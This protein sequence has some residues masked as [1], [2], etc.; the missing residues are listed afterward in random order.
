MKNEKKKFNRNFRIL[1]ETVVCGRNLR[2][3]ETKL[4]QNFTN[5]RTLETCLTQLKYLCKKY[6]YYIISLFMTPKNIKYHACK[7]NT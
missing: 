3:T 4:P 1:Y 6:T 5:F 7:V 2:K